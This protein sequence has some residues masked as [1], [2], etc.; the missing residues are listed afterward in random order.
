MFPRLSP[1]WRDVSL[2][3]R[4]PVNANIGSSLL[5]VDVWSR[6]RDSLKLPTGSWASRRTAKLRID[7]RP[8]LI[9]E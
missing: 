1:N 3:T 6:L 7:S 5:P 4:E 2:S 8:Q 9:P